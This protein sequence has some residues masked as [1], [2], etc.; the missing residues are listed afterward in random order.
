M[1]FSYHNIRYN[2]EPA[3]LE[4]TEREI[5]QRYQG[6]KQRHYPRPMPIVGT[7]CC[8]GESNKS[9]LNISD[10]PTIRKEPEKAKEELTYTHIENIR[11]SLEHRLQVAR[12]SGNQSLVRLLE[13]ESQQLTAY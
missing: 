11:R 5:A 8:G 4:V 7:S 9:L 12:V 13:A 1:K 3:T 2:Y 10:R 6:Q